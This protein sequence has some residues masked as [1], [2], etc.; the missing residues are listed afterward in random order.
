MPIKVRFSKN[1]FYH[2]AYGRLGRGKNEGRVYMLPDIFGEKE[3]YEVEIRDPTSKPPRVVG[4]REVT[5][6]K[7]IPSDAEIIDENVVDGLKQAINSGDNDAVEEL[8]EIENARMPTVATP[9]ALEKVTGRGHTPKA[10]SA[11]ERTT[12]APKRRRARSKAAA[13]AE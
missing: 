1:G 11:K 13:A 9:E 2:P 3:T 7:N 6:Y 10:Q 8:K 12:G 4:K 5:R